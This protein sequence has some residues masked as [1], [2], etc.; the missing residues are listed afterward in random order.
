MRLASSLCWVLSIPS[1]VTAT[2]DGAAPVSGPVSTRLIART[3]AS[4]ACVFNV[5]C[6]RC[7]VRSSRK[8]GSPHSRLTNSK[9]AGDWT[10]VTCRSVR[11]TK[12]PMP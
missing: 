9:R 3:I 6:G 11:W 10:S 1:P 4:M 7:M 5:S 12:Q 8:R 2:S